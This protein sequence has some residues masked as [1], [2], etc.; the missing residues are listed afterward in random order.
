M[1]LRGAT[2]GIG[3]AGFGSSTH[4]T[5]RAEDVGDVVERELAGAVEVAVA[6]A[7]AIANLSSE[8]V[9]ESGISRSSGPRVYTGGAGAVREG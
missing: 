7:V 1:L 5:Q 2:G 6:D 3:D 4:C 8:G 9:R